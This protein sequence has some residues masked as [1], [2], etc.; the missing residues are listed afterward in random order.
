MWLNGAK[1]QAEQLILQQMQSW[2]F[3][4]LQRG[5]IE[6]FTVDLGALFLSIDE[7]REYI[8]FTY[9][10]KSSLTNAEVVCILCM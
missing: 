10:C 8:N 9:I 4:V 1:A 7:K 5:H 3:I 6:I 2:E